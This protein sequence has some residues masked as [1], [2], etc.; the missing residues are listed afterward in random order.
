MALDTNDVIQ[1][2]TTNPSVTASI[3]LFTLNNAGDYVLCE[4]DVFIKVGE[5]YYIPAYSRTTIGVT[6]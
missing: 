6:P 3:P 4:P 2:S 1:T 5:D